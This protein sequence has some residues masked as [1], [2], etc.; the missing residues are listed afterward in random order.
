MV[1]GGD[2]MRESKS[3]EGVLEGW[4]KLNICAWIPS[5]PDGITPNS[6]LTGPKKK[7][8]M[9]VYICMYVCI[10]V[11]YVTFWNLNWD[12]L[13]VELVGLGQILDDY[14]N[15]ENFISCMVRLPLIRT[16]RWSH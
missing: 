15:I 6:D 1:V 14:L 13:Q 7:I 3:W 16:K 8:Y 11:H 9:Y 12:L 2:S 4:G 10:L 5:C